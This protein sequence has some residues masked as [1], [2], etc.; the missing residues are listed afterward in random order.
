MNDSV[1]NMC[2]W[3]CYA[4]HLL[5][6]KRCA[7]KGKELFQLFYGNIS[8]KKYVGFDIHNELELFESNT[9]V[10]VCIWEMDEDKTLTCIRRSLNED[11]YMNL[12]L[13]Q[14]HFCYISRIDVIDGTK[15]KC[16]TCGNCWPDMRD[17]KRHLPTCEDFK[18][19]DVF[20]KYPTVYEPKRNL[21]VELNEIFG[22]QCDFI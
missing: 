9:N 2:F 15:Y 16:N 22:T 3:N 10:G 8:N 17:L 1:N 5:Q 6:N 14:N 20:A 13:Y 18:K 7:K 19:E 4:F 11:N 21:I 12:L